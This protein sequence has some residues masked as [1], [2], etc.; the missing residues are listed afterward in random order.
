[1]L[2]LQRLY[3]SCVLRC[4]RIHAQ[5]SGAALCPQA[6]QLTVSSATTGSVSPAHR[7]VMARTTVG[8][9]VMRAA[10]AQVR[11]TAIKHSL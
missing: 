11:V 4:C 9:G 8:T 2:E 10:A 7:N 5:F 3:L 1:M 6:V